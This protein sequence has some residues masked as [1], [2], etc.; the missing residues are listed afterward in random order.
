[1]AGLWGGA[2]DPLGSERWELVHI[3]R[4]LHLLNEQRIKSRGN[5]CGVPMPQG[6]EA[7]LDIQKMRWGWLCLTGNPGAMREGIFAPQIIRL[8]NNRV[9]PC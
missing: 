4:D 9:P 7:T 5:Y 8:I 2:L 3:E 6:V 1:M